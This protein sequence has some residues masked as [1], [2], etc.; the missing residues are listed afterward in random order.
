M[1]S[2]HLHATHLEEDL[3]DVLSGTLT[4]EIEGIVGTGA[5]RR[6]DQLKYRQCKRLD[7]T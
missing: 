4:Q 2:S 5:S 7:E 3:E 6:R 1:A